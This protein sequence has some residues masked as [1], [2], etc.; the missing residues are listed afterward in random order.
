M[1]VLQSLLIPLTMMVGWI[2]KNKVKNDVL[3]N[4]LIPYLLFGGNLLL[5]IVGEVSPAA[6]SFGVIT[7]I[8]FGFLGPLFA[9]AI[10]A[11]A[12]TGQ[13]MLFHALLKKGKRVALDSRKP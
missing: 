8:S 6:A 2:L 5:G 11:F 3:Q 9:A 13:A 12:N 7:G 10:N 1:D 4:D